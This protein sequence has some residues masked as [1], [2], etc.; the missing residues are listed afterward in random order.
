MIL[1][2]KGTKLRGNVIKEIIKI[3]IKKS[4]F[5]KK[6]FFLKRY[7]CATLEPQVN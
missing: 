1:R 3:L 2:D 5:W 4:A 6:L 7:L